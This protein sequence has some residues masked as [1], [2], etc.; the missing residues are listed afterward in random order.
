MTTKTM[1]TMMMLMMLMLML[2]SEKSQ[3][4]FEY[5]YRHRYEVYGIT[6]NCCE[7]GAH[8]KER[9]T[10]LYSCHPVTAFS[11]TDLFLV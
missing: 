3:C 11:Q 1:T 10:T 6:V 4:H 7:S 8:Y 9:E 5:S 2:I